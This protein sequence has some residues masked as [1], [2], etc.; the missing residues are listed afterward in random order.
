MKKSSGAAAVTQIVN[1]EAQVGQ[2]EIIPGA[3]LENVTQ[4]DQTVVDGIFNRAASKMLTDHVVEG[5]ATTINSGNS[6]GDNLPNIMVNGTEY[7]PT[8]HLGTGGSGTAFEYTAVND[9]T[10]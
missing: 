7:K 6:V 9:D 3:Q 10:N 2:F 5:T 4:P 1:P 8:A